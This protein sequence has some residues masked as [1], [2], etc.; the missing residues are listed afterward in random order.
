LLKER[1]AVR[2]KIVVGGCDPAMFLAGKH[3]PKRDQGNLVPFLMRAA[4]PLGRSNA[5]KFTLLALI[6]PRRVRVSGDCLT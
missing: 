3:V 5:E 1:E 6:S 4:A 2:R